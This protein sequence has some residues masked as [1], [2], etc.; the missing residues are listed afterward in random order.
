MS[1]HRSSRG[2]RYRSRPMLSSFRLLCL[3]L[4]ILIMMVAR[5]IEIHCLLATTGMDGDGEVHNVL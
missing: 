5:Q 3:S 1:L 4:H 2:S